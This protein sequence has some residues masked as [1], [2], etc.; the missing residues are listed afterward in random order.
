MFDLREQHHVALYDQVELQSWM[1]LQLDLNVLFLRAEFI[2][3]KVY[4][5]FSCVFAVRSFQVFDLLSTLVE[6]DDGVKAG[7]DTS[8]SQ[9]TRSNPNLLLTDLPNVNCTVVD[10]RRICFKERLLVFH[11]VP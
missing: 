8:V 1:T 6:V 2:W 4:Y 3:F 9:A 5:A 10:F 7:R 11:S